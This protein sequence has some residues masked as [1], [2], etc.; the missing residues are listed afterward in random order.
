MDLSPYAESYKRQLD[1]LASG[2]FSQLHREA[3]KRIANA[4]ETSPNPA[5]GSAN[6]TGVFPSSSTS[7]AGARPATS[8][9]PP[10]SNSSTLPNHTLTTLSDL[11]SRPRAQAMHVQA[12]AA[13]AVAANVMAATEMASVAGSALESMGVDVPKL[14]PERTGVGLKSLEVRPETLAVSPSS[15]LP[16][17]PASLPATSSVPSQPL[18]VTALLTN[19]NATQACTPEKRDYLLSY[20]H[21]LYSKDPASTELLP[22]L[23]TLENIHEDHLPTLLLISCVYYTRGELESSY[24]YNKKLLSKDPNYVSR[25]SLV[26]DCESEC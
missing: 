22:L 8:T 21:T 4:V 12:A 13:A 3:L 14:V 19:A 5:A 24:Y 18:E 2:Y 23:H 7:I 10:T 25:V 16:A 1:A 15:A 26:Q 20:A 17:P 9:P 6:D 11:T